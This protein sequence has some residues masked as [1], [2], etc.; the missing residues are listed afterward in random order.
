MYFLLGVNISVCPVFALD[1]EAKP[2]HWALT[3]PVHTL[4][5]LSGALVNGVVGGPIDD[6]YHGF[7]KGTR[8]LAGKFGDEKGTGQQIAAAPLGGSVGLLLGTVYG[9]PHGFIHG[10]KTG[11]NKPFS[12]WSYVTMEETK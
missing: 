2:V 12:R 1:Y 11:W 8:Q 9:V 4:G 6:G 10:F 3:A 5:A 7:L